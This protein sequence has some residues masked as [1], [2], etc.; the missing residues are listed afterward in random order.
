MVLINTLKTTVTKLPILCGIA[1]LM[2]LGINPSAMAAILYDLTEVGKGSAYGI[3]DAGQVVGQFYTGKENHAFVWSKSSG[4][5]DLGTLSGG[6]S[7]VANDINDMGQVVGQSG[8]SKGDRAFVWSKS[9]GMTNLGTLG[10]SS[11]A[12]G[13]NNAG[14]VVGS[15]NLGL[16]DDSPPPTSRAFLW[17]KSTGLTNLGTLG[18]YGEY[19]Y[20]QA[21]DI[22][23]A[24]QVVGITSASDTATNDAGIA[25]AFVWTSSGGMT[26]LNT[27]LGDKGSS[28]A[29]AINNVGDIA[30]SI[31]DYTGPFISSAFVLK[32]N[33][34]DVIDLGSTIPVP[35]TDVNLYTGIAANDIN[36]AGQ[37]IGNGFFYR[38]TDG[39]FLWTST[40]G[41]RNLN[42]L[43]DPS[44]GW[45]L[46]T[47]EAINNKGQI[48]GTGTNQDGYGAAFLLT[49]R[50]AEPVPE[51]LT[52]GATLLA[53][54]GL[55]SLRYRQRQLHC[56]AK[57]AK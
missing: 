53:G 19:N 54:A 27:I 56:S 25:S 4:I 51:P 11:V 15:S 35:G 18:S 13:I 14:Q 38:Y 17:S 7:S 29:S 39:P 6:S 1:A 8:S 36:D 26:S 49:P 47:V 40:T 34:D 55:T 43:I 46:S 24:G 45:S 37:V 12:T 33:G 23:D 9:S 28:A 48:V 42:T 20:S 57:G 31:Y 3:N 52:I 32:S 44:L 41:V 50:S 10:G 5:T 30:G 22:N 21:L 16:T 2:T